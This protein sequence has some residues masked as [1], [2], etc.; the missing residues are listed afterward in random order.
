MG[1][2]IAPLI[3][4]Y[5]SILSST[6]D[7]TQLLILNNKKIIIQAAEAFDIN[8]T[9]LASIIYTE[10]SLNYDWTDDVFDKALALVGKNSSIGFCQVKLKTAYF[11]ER[12]LADSNS[13]FYPG[14]KYKNILKVNNN[15]YKIIE[16]LQVDSLNIYYAAAYLRIIQ[17]FWSMSGFSIDNKPEIIGSLYQLGLFRENG[18]PRE[19]HFNPQEN[20]FGKTVL[21]SLYLFSDFSRN[22]QNFI[23]K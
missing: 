12:Q 2:F 18:E 13:I 4:F 7:D 6:I 9:Y 16:Y 21:A 11:I 22:G 5:N 8:P 1:L 3:L 10:R 15:P 17:S 19:P 23:F 20:N 14:N